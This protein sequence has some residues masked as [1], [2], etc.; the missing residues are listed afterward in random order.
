MYCVDLCVYVQAGCIQ[1]R[2]TVNK[3]V[4]LAHSWHQMCQY[5][6]KNIEPTSVTQHESEHGKNYKHQELHIVILYDCVVG[7]MGNTVYFKEQ[8]YTLLFTRFQTLY[9]H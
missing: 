1:A 8:T 5:W 9:C 7:C 3:D 2:R 4:D 6:V